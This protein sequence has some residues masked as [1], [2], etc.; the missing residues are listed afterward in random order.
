MVVQ[1]DFD[2]VQVRMAIKIDLYVNNV[3]QQCRLFRHVAL[4][5]QFVLQKISMLPK[6][7]VT[8]S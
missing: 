2:A 7:Y 5:Q 1:D 4:L 3:Y 6:V 8:V